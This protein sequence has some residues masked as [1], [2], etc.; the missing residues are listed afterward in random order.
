MLNGMGFVWVG[1]VR[2]WLGRGEEVKVFL[3]SSMSARVVGGSGD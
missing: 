1:V 2:A 3:D